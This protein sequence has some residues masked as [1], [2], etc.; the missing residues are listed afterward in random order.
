MKR[1]LSLFLCLLM[2]L[3]LFA[4]CGS[5]QLETPEETK[6]EEKTVETKAETPKNHHPEIPA[7]HRLSAEKIVK[8][9]FH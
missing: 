8:G 7:E 9:Y 4:A 2:L 1:T 3:P 6:P 5:K